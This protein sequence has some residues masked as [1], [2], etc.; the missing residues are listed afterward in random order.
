[1]EPLKLESLEFLQNGRVFAQWDGLDG[2][3]AQEGLPW[4]GEGSMGL[5]SL[6]E[7]DFERDLVPLM[8]E[9]GLDGL[10][11]GKWTRVTIGVASPVDGPFDPRVPTGIIHLYS[12]IPLPELTEHFTPQLGC[13]GEYQEPVKLEERVSDPEVDLGAFKLDSADIVAKLL[14]TTDM[15]N[16]FRRRAAGDHVIIT[17]PETCPAVDKYS[18]YVSCWREQ[19]TE[20]P[21]SGSIAVTKGFSG[22]TQRTGSLRTETPESLGDRTAAVHGVFDRSSV[23]LYMKVPDDYAGFTSQTWDYRG[24]ITLDWDHVPNFVASP[25]HFTRPGYVAHAQRFFA[26][27]QTE[28]FQLRHEGQWPPSN[29]LLPE[30]RFAVPTEV[31]LT[32][33]AGTST[34]LVRTAATTPGVLSMDGAGA[35]GDYRVSPGVS[36]SFATFW[37]WQ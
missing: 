24:V 27:W 6:E 14:P 20:F 37:L 2:K 25:S 9:F 36:R 35:F 29:C 3:Q 13:S 8:K 4:F 7:A 32:E 16:T 23:A 1:M 17:L 18:P 5:V 10:K 22:T 26:N 19:L 34:Q 11:D 33:F 31:F 15:R 12:E 28:R 30:M 21:N